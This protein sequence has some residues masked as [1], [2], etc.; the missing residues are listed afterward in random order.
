MVLVDLVSPAL[1]QVHHFI[2]TSLG[3]VYLGRDIKTGAD[4]A[5]KIGGAGQLPSRLNHEYNVYRSIAGS[6]GTSSVFWYGKEGPYDVIVMEYLGDS[7]GSIIENRL[8]C[9]NTGKV[10]AYA[11]QMVRLSY[12]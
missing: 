6:T 12:L 5:L 9:G 1:A 8:D 4:V 2:D 10:F 3:S 11:S 7:L